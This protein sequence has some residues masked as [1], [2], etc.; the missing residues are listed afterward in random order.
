MDYFIEKILCLIVLIFIYA[1]QR[2]GNKTT[3]GDRLHLSNEY[4]TINK[5]IW[6]L[7]KVNELSS[8][9]IFEI[10]QNK[11]KLLLINIKAEGN[12]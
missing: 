7:L 9:Y 1:H 12:I 11:I 5:Q 3:I 10:F 4:E 2:L 8:L 6:L